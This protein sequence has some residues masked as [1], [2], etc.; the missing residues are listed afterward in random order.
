MQVI[1]EDIRR[2]SKREQRAARESYELL[3]T[4][5]EHR[6]DKLTEITIEAL[7]RP[8]KVPAAVMELLTRIMQAM[9]EGKPITLVPVA[10]EL[11]TQ[12][13]AELLGCSRPHLVKL[14]ETGEIPFT[15]VGRHRRV[16]YEDMIQYKNQQHRL[17]EQLLKEIMQSDEESGLY[18]TQR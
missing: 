1:N 9:S 6:A 12:A 15:K 2:P 3:R 7:K 16:K 13:A 4:L 18:D 11:T 10:T 5:Q 8:L 17:R 14:L